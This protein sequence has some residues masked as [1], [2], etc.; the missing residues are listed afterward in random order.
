MTV[1]IVEPAKTVA[2]MKL[3]GGP[4]CKHCGHHHSHGFDGFCFKGKLLPDGEGQPL[5]DALREGRPFEIA[6]DELCL[7]PY[8]HGLGG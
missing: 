1:E 8:P 4:P 6:D 3:C 7:C 2:E 5:L